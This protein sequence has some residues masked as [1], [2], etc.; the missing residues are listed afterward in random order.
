MC[1]YLVERGALTRQACQETD[2][3][4]RFFFQIKFK[5]QLQYIIKRK[6]W[7]KFCNWFS[8]YFKSRLWIERLLQALGYC[9]DAA[10]SASELGP[11]SQFS[12]NN[13]ALDKSDQMFPGHF[14]SD[15]LQHWGFHWQ[16]RGLAFTPSTCFHC[17]LIGKKQTVNKLR[18]ESDLRNVQVSGTDDLNRG[19]RLNYRQQPCS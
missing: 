13:S 11:V 18:K 6:I 14:H 12:S 8:L 9:P 4:D 16:H 15:P 5:R 10:C 3:A 2:F 1:W 7:I 17:N 19:F